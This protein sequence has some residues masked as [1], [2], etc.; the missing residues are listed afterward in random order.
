MKNFRKNTMILSVSLILLASNFLDAQTTITYSENFT[1]GTIYT[2]S[3]RQ[4]INWSSFIDQLSPRIYASV[5]I[6]G[7]NEVVG[8]SVTDA[9]IATA[10][11]NALYTN[12]SGSWTTGGRVWNV[13][14]CASGIEISASTTGLC[15]CES[16]YTVRPQI[17]NSSWGGVNG[18]SCTGGSQTMTV[19]FVSGSAVT[20]TFNYTGSV[21]YFTIPT[22][23]TSVSIET[24]G[25][26]GASTAYSGGLGGYAKGNLAVTPGEVINL[27]VGGKGGVYSIGDQGTWTSGGWNGGG[28]GYHSGRGGGGASDIR[29]GGT[30]LT[31]RVIVAAGGGGAANAS[32][33]IGG[34]G[35]GNIGSYGLRFNASDPGFCGQGGTQSAGGAACTNYGSAGAG[36]LGQGGNGGTS[37]NNDGS[38]GGG[39]YYGGGGGDQG[40]AGGGSSCT[41]GV[42]FA[43]TTSGLRSGDGQINITY[44]SFT[45][46]QTFIY[47]GFSQTWVVPPGVTSLDVEAWG[48]QGG[49]DYA[50]AAGGLG[51][52]MKGTFSVTP[53]ETI[54]IA[55]GGHGTNYGGN[56]SGGGGGGGSYIW[57]ADNTT[58]LML[59][60]GGGGG[61]WS[62]GVGI[63]LIGTAGGSP[64]SGGAGGSGGSGGYASIVNGNGGSGGAGWNSNG[65]SVG[66]GYSYGGQTKPGFAGGEGHA[67]YGGNGGFGGGG[68]TTYGGGGGGGYSGG[69][70][71]SNGV[72]G[73]G[74][75]GSYNIGTNQS[76][77]AGVRLAN[78][79]VVITYTLSTTT[80]PNSP[81]I[82]AGTSSVN[83]TATVAPNPGGGSVEFFVNGSSVGSTSVVAGTGIA[84]LAYNTSSL[85][86]GSY[87]IR[88]DF[89]G[90]NGNPPSSS[91]PSSNGTLTITNPGYNW[92]GTVSTNWSTPGNWSTNLVPSTGNNVYIPSGKPRWPHITTNPSSPSVCNTLSIASGAILTIDAGK[93]LTVNSSISNTAGSSGLI[94]ESGGS[95]INST[96]GINATVKFNIPGNQWH[97]ISAPV[98]GAVSGFFTGKYLQKHTESSNIYTDIIPIDLPLTPMKG[99]A[100]WGD[101]SGFTANYSGL[102]N[103]GAKSFSTTKSGQGWNLVGNPY[104]SS[105]D[106]DASLGWTKTNVNNATYIHVNSS[107]WATYINGSGVNGG[108]RY[109]APGQGFFVSAAAAGNL[110]MSD[111]VRVQNATTFFKNSS[112]VVNNLIR[113]EVSGNIYKDEAIVRFSPEASS[114]FDGDYDAYKLYGDVDEAPQ[115]YTLGSDELAI[116]S[117]P[118]P[119]TVPVGIHAGVDGLYSIAATEINNF[120]EVSLE[121]TKTGIFT[122]LIKNSYSFSYNTEENEQRFLLHFGALLINE[123]QNSF[124]SIFSYEKTV[125]ID[126]RTDVQA[127]VYIYNISG[128][129]VANVLSA[130]GIEKINLAISGNYIVKVIT[131]NWTVVKK[132]WIR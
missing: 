54:G 109:I 95:I 92:E 111:A 51:A 102:L 33:C 1:Y 47:T 110:A 35:G 76:N 94:I 2:S 25:A 22:G 44:Q 121:D 75:G 116:N 108:T 46:D 14:V 130:H 96:A 105:I 17:G 90:Y 98:S 114:E 81:V 13:G 78:G 64:S 16:A 18:P 20:Q 30:T 122:D 29:K 129:L 21:Q 43:S 15:T 48:A 7:S 118:E 117:L 62:T 74:G 27:Y 61:G 32:Q 85:G 66:N 100:L 12:V 42:S 79:L 40:G 57:H 128:Q 56:I 86:V 91:N 59:A 9:T 23:V 107:S 38:G 93:A 41:G 4:W 52:R 3:D 119:Q 65:G 99:F 103:A 45:N 49:S 58:E 113:L 19:V 123:T 60:A 8:V 68:G 83:L 39:G 55:V 10:I 115:I 70:G 77:S 124:A 120:S 11:A 36:G 6:K 34:A 82:I 26:Q 67:I 72:S 50:A 87:I 106:W 63:G 131:N 24:W 28:L 127:E 69:G 89:G 101:A 88:A 132:V 71:G 53:G 73:G 97:L 125:L 112:E 104:P 37:A 80:A 31:N 126:L 84:T 5:T